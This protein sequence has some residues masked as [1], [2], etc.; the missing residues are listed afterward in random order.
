VRRAIKAHLGSR[1]VSR[2]IYGAIIGLALVVA[3][4]EHPP[5]PEVVAATILATAAAV[6]L[7][8]LY[9]EVVGTETQ[10]RRRIEREDLGHILGDAAAEALGVGLPAVFFILAAANWMEVETAFT[11]AKWSGLGLIGLYGF[12]G[13]RLAG[14]GLPASLLQALAVGLIGGMLIALKAL[15]H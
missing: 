15:I 6:G 10:A 5:R 11:V 12:W 7:A 13:A 8:A 4:E 3:L 2:V 9:S 14:A 1:Q